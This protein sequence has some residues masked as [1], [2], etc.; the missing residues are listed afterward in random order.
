MHL[1]L[2]LARLLALVV[3]TAGVALGWALPAAHAA[4]VPPGQIDVA[5]SMSDG[6]DLEGIAYLYRWDAELVDFDYQTEDVVVGSG[7]ATL[8]F[9]GLAP[10]DYYVES[11]TTSA[12]TS[13]GT[14]AMPPCPRRD[15]ATRVS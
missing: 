14:P 13:S 2:L 15:P 6:G 10:G 1:R 4:V 9:T 3:T 11:P 5:I 7:T 12:A 8:S